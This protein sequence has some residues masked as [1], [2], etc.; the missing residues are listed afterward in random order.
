MANVFCCERRAFSWS[1][2]LMIGGLS[3]SCGR[4]LMA[5]TMKKS[6]NVI[7]K[8]NLAKLLDA[9]N[10]SPVITSEARKALVV[11]QKLPKEEF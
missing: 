7:I 9:Q 3:L 8:H 10:A 11:G 4:T 1:F 2:L 6:Q 5:M